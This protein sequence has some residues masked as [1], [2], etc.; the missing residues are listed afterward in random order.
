[1]AKSVKSLACRYEDAGFNKTNTGR[2]QI[3]GSA[4]LARRDCAAAPRAH[5]LTVDCT[6]AEREA[7][8][9]CKRKLTLTRNIK[10][11]I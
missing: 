6:R 9:I 3:G 2:P 1:M 8:N 7:G 10:K 4:R 5:P 11:N